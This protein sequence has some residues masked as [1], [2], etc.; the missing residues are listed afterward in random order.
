MH[1]DYHNIEGHDYYGMEELVM[2]R[3]TWVIRDAS[4]ICQDP[5]TWPVWCLFQCSITT[6]NTTYSFFDQRL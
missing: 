6:P 1:S 3:D 5:I 4:G 2:E